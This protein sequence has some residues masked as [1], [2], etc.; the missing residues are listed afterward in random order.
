MNRNRVFVAV[1]GV[2]VDLRRQVGAGVL[3][4]VEAERRHL[5]VTQVV[6]RVGVE[7]AARQRF[8]VTTTGEHT[9]AFLGRV[10]NPF[11]RTLP[12]P[13]GEGQAT[14]WAATNRAHGGH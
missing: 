11:S 7:H 4:V 6:L 10:V 3:F 1:S 8:F 13:G 9:G 12:E 2:Q 5:R 14:G